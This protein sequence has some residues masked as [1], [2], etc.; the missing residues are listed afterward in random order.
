MCWDH[1]DTVDPRTSK[2]RL[3]DGTETPYCVEFAFSSNAFVMGC[4]GDYLDD[5]TCGTFVEVHRIGECQRQQ[6]NLQ[7][8]VRAES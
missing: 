4:R 8:S 5:L 3:E 2:C 7:L 6:P 1:N